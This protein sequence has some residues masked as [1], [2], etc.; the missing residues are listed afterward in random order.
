MEFFLPTKFL[1]VSDISERQG[2]LVIFFSFP[3]GS[4]V[5]E[6]HWPPQEVSSS[7]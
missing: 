4:T 5:L 2:T 1:R 3:L 6:G 7:I